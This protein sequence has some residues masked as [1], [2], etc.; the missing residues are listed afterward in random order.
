MIPMLS[1]LVQQKALTEY[2]QSLPAK[3]FV[4]DEARVRRCI[5]CYG[6]HLS[7]LS[8]R[9]IRDK[10][11][12]KH[13]RSAIAAIKQGEKMARELEIDTDRIKRKVHILLE[14]CL[15]RM[16]DQVRTQAET[17][18]ITQIV[19]NDG[20]RSVR[21]VSGIDPRIAGELGRGLMRWA[22]LVGMVDGDAGGGNSSGMTLINL[23]MPTDG[24]SLEQRWASAEA[25]AA[26]V[27]VESQAVEAPQPQVEGQ[28]P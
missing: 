8:N 24:A 28:A 26:A 13:E 7:G 25:P 16:M 1:A 6:D 15:D 19:D 18:L 3:G 11:G 21:K 27:D 12:W 4:R 20:K 10:Y 2:T 17:G 22:Q 14:E 9:A 23:Q 5:D